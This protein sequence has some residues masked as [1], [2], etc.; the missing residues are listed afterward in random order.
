MNRHLAFP[1]VATLALATTGAAEPPPL[2]PDGWGALRIGMAEADAVRILK[3]TVPP[4]DDVNS[5]ACRVIDAPGDSQLAIITEKGR[6]ARISL[7][8]PGAL[9]TDK[10]FGVGSAEADIRRAYGRGLQVT[11]HSYD[12]EPAHY[13]TY[14]TIPKRRGVRYETNQQGVVTT[15]HVGGPAIQYIEGCL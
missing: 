1:L 6:V 9:R 3:T 15:V 4:D 11:T 10:G 8:G 5:F 14:W 12:E 2:T 13:L 7:H